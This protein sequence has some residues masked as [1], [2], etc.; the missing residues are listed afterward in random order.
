M[1]RYGTIK[2]GS[3]RY[4]MSIPG[5]IQTFDSILRIYTQKTVNLDKKIIIPS[6]RL[7][8]IDSRV[9][10]HQPHSSVSDTSFVLSLE[11]TDTIDTLY[12]ILKSLHLLQDINLIFNLPRSEAMDSK[13][14]ISRSL[15][16][17]KDL[18]IWL[19]SISDFRSDTHIN[20][21][22]YYKTLSDILLNIWTNLRINGVDI[23]THGFTIMHDT[24]VE[25]SPGVNIRKIEIPLKDGVTIV[26]ID[27][28]ERVIQ[29]ALALNCLTEE[30][31]IAKKRLLAELI[32]GDIDLV[33]DTDPYRHYLCRYSGNISLQEWIKDGY[34]TIPFRMAD[35]YLYSDSKTSWG[36]GEII[37]KGSEPVDVI[38][39]VLGP[40][41]AP[42]TISIN[43]VVM[44]INKDLLEDDIIII[45]TGKP[46]VTINGDDA[47]TELDGDLPML[48]PGSNSI[49]CSTT[50]ISLEWRDKWLL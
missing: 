5:L 7:F 28:S 1:A 25:L 39:K 49:N 22:G 13:V 3:S 40:V 45:D 17:N 48:L 35:P 38:I 42:W 10:L 18:M 19:A 21:S 11:Y 46:D 31:Y 30:E 9:F 14:V 8:Q 32:S 26:G 41:T 44:T 27:V 36:V 47:M 20:L 6:D 33:F 29:L 23:T 24:E 37:N 50:T 15:T 12:T 43:S 4:G 2:Y 34:L 16:V